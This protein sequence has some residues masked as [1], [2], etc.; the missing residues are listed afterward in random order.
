MSKLGETTDRILEMLKN[1]DKVDLEEIR[2]RLQLSGDA[3]FNF[4]NEFGLIEFEEG[5]VRITKP[6]LEL[7]NK[8]SFV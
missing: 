8:V 3:I 4:M 6:G 2:D 7:L 1:G 5:K